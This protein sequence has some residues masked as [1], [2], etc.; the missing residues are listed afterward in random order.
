MVGSLKEQ[1]TMDL[2]TVFYNQAEFADE[3]I[4]DGEPITAVVEDVEAKDGIIESGLE[5]KSVRV[6]KADIHVRLQHG[7]QVLL[8]LDPGIVD[9]GEVWDIDRVKDHGDEYEVLFTRYVS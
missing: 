9:G 4:W 1:I 5:Q 3:I 7:D 6:K 8:T 2:D